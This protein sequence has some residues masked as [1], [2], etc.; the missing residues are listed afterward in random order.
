MTTTASIETRGN[1]LCEVYPRKVRRLCQ[2]LRIPCSHASVSSVQRARCS[3][4]TTADALLEQ[5]IL[6]GDDGSI[7]GMGLRRDKVEKV[8]IAVA[9]GAFSTTADCV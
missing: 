1:R 8:G 4:N 2:G 3:Q 5:Y 7:G 6:L 9:L